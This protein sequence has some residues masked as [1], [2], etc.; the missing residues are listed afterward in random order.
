MKIIKNFD[1][2]INE[3]NNEN[4]ITPYNFLDF[5]SKILTI[6]ALQN[7]PEL[8]SA[9]DFTVKNIEDYSDDFVKELVDPFLIKINN[10]IKNNPKLWK[11]EDTGYSG[12]KSTG[13]KYLL[14]KNLSIKEITK[15]IREE[16]KIEFPNWKFSI[17]SG[18]GTLT[19]SISV[20]IK[21]LPYNPYSEIYDEAYKNDTEPKSDF[22]RISIE[23][24]NMIYLKDLK[25]IEKI[26]NQYNYNDS[27][28]MIDY[29]DNRYYDTIKLDTDSI[30]M[31]Y[32]PNHPDVLKHLKFHKEWNEQALKRKQIA[33]SKKGKFKKGDAIIYSYD[34]DSQTIPKGDY[35]GIILK[36][37]NG[38][39]TFSKY[40]IKFWVNKIFR[41]GVEVE[42]EK[43]LGYITT[44]YDESKL[45]LK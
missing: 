26:V 42:L 15:L 39:G 27:N 19:S 30:M 23:K 40:E 38:R 1:S 10:I 32:Y 33:D 21:D 41:H 34:R 35:D 8:K 28:S 14:T 37:P 3:S 17:T 12:Y 18:G 13:N 20:E 24:Y 7:N 25:K 5:K 9:Y 22:N 11:S 16:L 45:R 43:P 2:F 36:S 6:V 29:S 4:I 31:K 44:L